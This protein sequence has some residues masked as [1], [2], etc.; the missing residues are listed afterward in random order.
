MSAGLGLALLVIGAIFAFALHL[1][2]PGLDGPMFGVILML[3]GLL[4]LG[5]SAVQANT[6]R[7]RTSVTRTEHADG[8]ETVTER[9]T[10]TDRPSQV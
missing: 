5:L 1:P 3:A 4:V 9:R 2:I 6:S 7:K 10:V 8:S